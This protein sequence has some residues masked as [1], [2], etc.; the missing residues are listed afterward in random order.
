MDTNNNPEVLND[1]KIENAFNESDKNKN[2][3]LD[4]SE[5][6]SA[7][8]SLNLTCENLPSNSQFN[9]KDFK[10]LVK[11]IQSQK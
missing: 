3:T 9:L 7:L 4:E 8:S 10:E 2:G 5:T 11:S 6:K 1:E